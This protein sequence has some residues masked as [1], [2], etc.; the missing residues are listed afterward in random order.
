MA[1]DEAK[2]T[3]S[4]RGALV[5]SF[6]TGSA[7]YAVG[8]AFEAPRL[9]ISG[10]LAAVA[11]RRS[12]PNEASALMRKGPSR[13]HQLTREGLEAETGIEPMSTDLQSAA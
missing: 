2:N 8:N 10:Q 13:F 3:D 1:T 12:L 11:Q 5:L 6:H 4:A 9:A 7:R